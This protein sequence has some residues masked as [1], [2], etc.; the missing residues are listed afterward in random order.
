MHPEAVGRWAVPL[1]LV[2]CALLH[3]SVRVCLHVREGMGQYMV[4]RTQRDS[5]PFNIKLIRNLVLDWAG[6]DMYCEHLVAEICS[7][8]AR[9]YGC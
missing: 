7:A 8:V 1:P 9:V 2:L 5:T 3:A 6:E 4:A